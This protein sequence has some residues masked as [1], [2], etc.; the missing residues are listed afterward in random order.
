MVAP[1]LNGFVIKIL[2][3]YSAKNQKNS[4]K[5]RAKQKRVTMKYRNM[6]ITNIGTNVYPFI[7]KIR[8]RLL[9]ETTECNI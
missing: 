4:S 3:L 7:T 5:N 8:R 2:E 1:N 6:Y 9:I